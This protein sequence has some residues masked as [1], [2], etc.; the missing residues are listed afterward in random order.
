[1]A[2]RIGSGRFR[3]RVIATPPGEGTRPPLAL[4]RKSLF[5]ILAPRLDG[6]RVLDLFAGSGS[7]GLEAV[8]RGA[9][10][11]T[12]V[13]SAPNAFGVMRD[14]VEKLGVASAARLMGQDALEAVRSLAGSPARYDVVFLDP[15]FKE[16]PPEELLSMAAALVDWGGVLVLRIPRSR[17]MPELPGGPTLAREKVYGAS[18]I[19]FYEK[20]AN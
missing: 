20:E 11:V 9:A 16:P 15:P 6:A 1:M 14:N 12:M 5:D 19:G 8:S 2:I 13:E 4:I 18:K 17:R 7:F 10:E 3:G